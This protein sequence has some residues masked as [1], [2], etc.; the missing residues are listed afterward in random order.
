MKFKRF[1]AVI[2]AS[3]LLF[4]ATAIAQEKL[5]DFDYWASLCN[6]LLLAEDYEKALEACDQAVGLF[7]NDPVTW[8]NR[9][10][11]LF[12]L[13][14]YGD[15]LVSYEQVLR[16]SPTDSLALAKRCASLTALGR[17]DD[18]VV[19]CDEGLEID[20]DWGEGTP[21]IAWYNRGVA[22]TQVGNHSEALESYDWAIRT[23][24][25]Y[26][27]AYAGRCLSLAQFSRYEE[28]LVACDRAIQAGN[29]GHQNAATALLNRGRV[30]VKLA[31]T[32]NSPQQGLQFYQDALQSYND[33]LAIDPDNEE[34]WTEQGTVLGR[35]GRN[36]E[37]L[38]SHDWAL[39]L[40]ENYALALANRCAALNRLGQY[41]DAQASCD[42]ALQEGDDRWGL[43]GAS[44]AWSQRGN[45][46]AGQFKYEEG[47]ASVNRAISLNPTYEETWLN[48]STLLWL[49]ERY[50]EALD[51]TQEA[52]D[53]NPESSRA[54]YNRGR[55]LTTLREYSEAIIAYR[56][57][58]EGD[59]QIGGQPSLEKI[60]LNLSAVLWRAG[61]YSEG[62]AEA[63]RAIALNPDSALGWYNRAL[64][65]MSN[66]QYTKALEAY[67][68]TLELNPNDGNAWMGLGITQR[69]LKAY[70]ESLAAL[71]KALELNPDNTQAQ[72]N[73]E[74]VMKAIEELQTSSP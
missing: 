65:L 48:Q 58:L 40:S 14:Q 73:L 69:A 20:G 18:A 59:A 27:P 53:L 49:L 54:W 74:A 17:T 35:L 4:P 44:Y 10:D 3:L 43:E 67:E 1:L 41:S 39:K 6:T 13:S 51:A 68:R 24:P 56:T 52:I 37:S 29:W 5:V 38:A 64:N 32:Q 66:R 57:A 62:A 21:A 9:G 55:I 22:M 16:R 63:Q 70:P 36:T 33:A 8:N 25:S 31:P 28:A 34:T 60:Y 72:D 15:A 46:L 61:R 47:L 2:P 23:N 26:S 19:A 12:A 7:P 45:S 71:Q 11:V 50:S 30:L 42:K